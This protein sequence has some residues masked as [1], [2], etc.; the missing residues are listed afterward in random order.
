MT[1]NEVC[2]V[3]NDHHMW[4]RAKKEEPIKL[5]ENDGVRNELDSGDTLRSDKT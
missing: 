2:S 5:K 3:T 1:A 4:N